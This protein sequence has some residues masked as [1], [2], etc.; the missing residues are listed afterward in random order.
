MVAHV[1]LRFNWGMHN[2][3][4]YYWHEVYT[5][6]WQHKLTCNHILYGRN[7][8]D[9]IVHLLLSSVD[10]LVGTSIMDFLRGLNHLLWVTFTLLEGLDQLIQ[11]RVLFLTLHVVPHHYQSLHAT[12]LTCTLL[13]TDCWSDCFTWREHY[14]LASS[15]WTWVA[16]SAV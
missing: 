11:C 13:A 6:G 16:T 8:L 4:C 12:S 15:V 9:G 7:L 3:N 14:W 10:L 2:T 1:A 5:S